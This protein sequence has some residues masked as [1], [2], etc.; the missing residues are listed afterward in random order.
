MRLDTKRSGGF[1]LLAVVA[2]TGL[3]ACTTKLTATRVENFGNVVKGDVYYL[4]RVEFQVNLSRE[5]KSCNVV[6]QD[7]AQ[8]ALAW[9]GAQLQSARGADTPEEMLKILDAIAA[10]AV[11][12]RGDIQPAINAALGTQWLQQLVVTPPAVPAKSGIKPKGKAGKDT[13]QVSDD[14]M[15]RLSAAIRRLNL[16]PELKLEVDMTAQVVATF[17]PDASHTYTLDYV[18]MAEALKATDY[19]TEKY[20]GNTLKSVNVTMDDQSGPVIVKTISGITKLAAAAS[21]FPIPTAH[22]AKAVPFQSFDDWQQAQ[23]DGDVACKADIRWK[24]YQRAGLDA[25]SEA[26]AESALALQKEVDKL[27]DEQVK[28]VAALEKA[29]ATLKE[30]DDNDPRRPAASAQVIKAKGDVKLAAKNVLDAKAKLAAA[31][32]ANGKVDS[33]LASVRKALTLVSTTTFQPTPTFL[34]MDLPGANEAIQ[35]WLAPTQCKGNPQCVPPDR[36]RL[37]AGMSAQVALHAPSLPAAS[38]ADTAAVGVFYRQPLKSTLLVCKAQPCTA[39]GAIVATPDA[40]L[41]SSLFDV[42]QLGP[43][44]VLPLKNGA[45]QNNTIAASFAENGAL[46]KL[47]YKSNAAAAKGAEVLESSADTLMKFREAK[48]NQETSKLE[49]SASEYAA[50]K[51][52]VDAQLALEK[53]QAELDKFREGKSTPTSTPE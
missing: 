9:L 10:D 34:A 44:A 7:D 26:G 13:R 19:V 30:L 18:P 14:E 53:S 17:P 25:Q 52:L 11:M 1:A 5:L 3:S 51:K 43:L 20:P 40:V 35:A 2:L 41:T 31:L 29:E 12:R 48:R 46:I 38:A 16:R 47:A 4:P 23:S 27:N 50:R 45:F 24:L 32:Q 39:G 6:Y 28:A 33:R 37:A 36:S 15:N 42:P 21:G 22:A 8:A 49:A